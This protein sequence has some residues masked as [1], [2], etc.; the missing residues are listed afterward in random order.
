GCQLR[1]RQNVRRSLELAAK[2]PER[3]SVMDQRIVNG[4]RVFAPESR[5]ALIDHAF[6]NG[7]LLVAVNAEKILHA[8]EQTRDIINRNLGYPDGFGAVMALKKKGL[9]NVVKIPGCELWLDIVRAHYL[10]KKFYLVGGKDAAIE[11]VVTRL[12][13]EFPGI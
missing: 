13:Q 5:E 7:S 11:N 10:D 1:F 9:K 6:A 2:Q 3:L 12:H 8:T 4:V